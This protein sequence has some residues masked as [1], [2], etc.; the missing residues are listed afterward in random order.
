[1]RAEIGAVLQLVA[2]HFN[3]QIVAFFHFRGAERN[4]AADIAAHVHA[5]AFAFPRGVL[6]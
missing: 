3:H 1:M 6:C 2:G 4:G 5:A